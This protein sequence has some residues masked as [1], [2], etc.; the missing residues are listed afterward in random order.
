MGKN[1]DLNSFYETQEMDVAKPN[2][3]GTK[4]CN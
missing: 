3:D 2:K 1:E 4:N